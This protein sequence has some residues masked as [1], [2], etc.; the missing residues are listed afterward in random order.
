MNFDFFLKKAAPG[1]AATRQADAI[2]FFCGILLGFGEQRAKEVRVRDDVGALHFASLVPG[3][4]P[5]G[6][7]FLVWREHVTLSCVPRIVCRTKGQDDQAEQ[8]IFIWVRDLWSCCVWRGGVALWGGCCD[9]N[10]CPDALC[11]GFL[12]GFFVGGVASAV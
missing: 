3:C 9:A 6:C 8:V 7:S 1:T 10:E 11:D 12:V 4:S 5:N 2:L